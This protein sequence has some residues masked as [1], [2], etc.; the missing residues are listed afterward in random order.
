MDERQEEEEKKG[1][2]V[3][4]STE[5]RAEERAEETTEEGTE[6][7]EEHLKVTEE[8]CEDERCEEDSECHSAAKR[9]RVCATFTDSQ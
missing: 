2:E 1:G 9:T 8:A 3:E 6:E 7:T 4:E 5:E